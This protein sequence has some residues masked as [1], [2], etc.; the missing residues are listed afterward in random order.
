MHK[1]QGHAVGYVASEVD[2]LLPLVVVITN[3][4][5]QNDVA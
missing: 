2:Q 5:F 3:F 4:L 1:D